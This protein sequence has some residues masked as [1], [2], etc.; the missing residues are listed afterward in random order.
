MRGYLAF[1]KKECLEQTRTYKLL[2]LLLV[3]FIF[4]MIS[5]LM[6]KL[7]PEILSSMPMDGI[8]IT[9]PEPTAIDSYSQFFKN[10]TQMGLIVLVLLFSGTLTTEL[11]KGTL[12]N[13][14]TK[15]LT[16]Y[17]VILAKYT[18]ALGLWSLALGLSL[19]V[20]YGY[21]AYFFSQDNIHHL[22]AS[23]GCLWLFGAMLLSFL[24]WAQTLVDSQ[25]GSLLLTGIYVAGLFLLNLFPQ[26]Q[27]Y[28][29]IVLVGEN[30]AML[31]SDYEVSLMGIPSCLTAILCV[32][33]LGLALVTFKNKRI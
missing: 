19:G 1:V 31:S 18:V 26:A 21:T 5:P 23:V 7:M 27:D 28:N 25:Y 16:R 8:T 24:M 11:S 20:T 9:V 10:L 6:A 32:L 33:F 17:S 29:P 15:G 22:F 13:V 14:L 3:F 2:I 12:I 4:G 30:V